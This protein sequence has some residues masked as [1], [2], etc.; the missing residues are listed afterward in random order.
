MLLLG[1]SFLN[2]PAIASALAVF[3]T[4]VGS[5]TLLPA[6]L[7][8]LR[9]RASSS[10]RAAATP[11]PTPASGPAGPRFI[12]RRPRLVAVV[13]LVVVAVIAL[14]VF[15]MQLGSARRRQRRPG[16]H[17]P[18]RLRPALRGLRPRLQRSVPGR[19]RAARQRRR[20]PRSSTLAGGDRRPTAS[21][22]S[23]PP[24]L[25]PAK[26]TATLDGLP[27]HQA[28]GH[29]RPQDLLDAPARAT[30]SRRS[31][32]QTG[33][34]AS[35]GGATATDGGPQRGCSPTSCRCSSWWSSACRCCCW[36]SCSARS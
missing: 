15:G 11:T 20:R 9:A 24:A 31:S 35:V 4:M 3:A 10:A 30:S 26:D 8:T 34:T 21:P 13:T 22:R 29:R 12:E 5:L 6:L 25:N 16:H 2:G 19:R 28:A 33:I 7:G 14:P 18:H 32:G 23:R 27:D 17:H 1:I 36:R